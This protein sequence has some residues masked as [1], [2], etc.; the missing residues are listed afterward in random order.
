M[1]SDR[2][3]RSPLSFSW[4]AWR[5]VLVRT[6]NEASSDN[7]GLAAA[8]IS[9]YAFLALLPLLAAIVLVYGLVADPQTVIDHVHEFAGAMPVEAATFLAEQLMYVVTTAAEKKGIGLVTA[10]AL[11]VFSARAAAG[12]IIGALNIAYEED[13][14]RGFIRVN[15]AALGITLGGVLFCVAGLL[16]ASSLAFLDDIAPAIPALGLSLTRLASGLVAALAVGGIALGLYKFGPCRAQP[17]L[18]WAIPGAVLFALVW[19]GLTI[20]FSFYVSEFSNFGA[21]YGSLATIAVFLTWLYIAS[22]ALLLGAELNAELEHETAR[23]STAGPDRPM[24]QRKAW[25]A[26]HIPD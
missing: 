4:N 10:L 3:A 19:T 9:F 23:D 6:W 13:E 14:K 8:G 7:I 21:T 26:D 2:A 25:V 18:V 15:L 12:A 17:R 20:G 1:N 11:S 24:G 22:Y 16:T 5:S